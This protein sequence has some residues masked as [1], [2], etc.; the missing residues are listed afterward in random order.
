MQWFDQKIPEFL[1]PWEFFEVHRRLSGEG[2]G[3][4]GR[5]FWLH[6]LNS[7]EQFPPTQSKSLFS[8]S[9]LN[10][11]MPRHQTS[12]ECEDQLSSFLARFIPTGL[13]LS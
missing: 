6:T 12:G 10:H 5:H 13:K 1:S 2:G 11:P 4:V 7:A 3:F 9:E 8:N